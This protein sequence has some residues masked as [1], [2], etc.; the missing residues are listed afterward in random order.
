MKHTVGETLISWHYHLPWGGHAA[1]QSLS[2][3]KV[4]IA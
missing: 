2:D 3:A 1:L 4:A